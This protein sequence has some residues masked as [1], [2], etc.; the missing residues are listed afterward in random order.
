MYLFDF[1]FNPYALLSYLAVVANT[2]VLYLV[3]SR[4]LK[5]SAN[6]WFVMTVLALIPWGLGEAFLRLSAN[7]TAASFWQA[8]EII[9][10]VFVSPLFLSFTLAYI[11]KENLLSRLSVQALLFGPALLFLFLGWYTDL[12]YVT[13]DPA[14]YEKVYHGWMSPT[15]PFFW[16]VTLWL[17]SLFIISIW[18]LF[19]YRRGLKDDKKRKQTILVIFGVLV[20]IV[21]GLTTNA[22]LPLLGFMVFEAAVPLTT[23][24][25]VTIAYAIF[26]YKLFVINLAMVADDIV[27]TMNEILIVLDTGHFI[28]FGNNAVE[29][30]LGYKKEELLGQHVRKLVGSDWPAFRDK[31]LQ[32]LDAG[33][34]V[35]GVEVNLESS[36]GKKIPVSFSS[37]LLKDENG[38]VFG[39]VGVATD[40]RKIQELVTN[41][42]AERNKL[43]TVMQSI[44]DGVL[45]LDLEGNIILVNPPAL[46]MLGLGREDILGKKL[47]DVLT[48]FDGDQRML[49]RDLIPTNK[50]DKDTI[51]VQK[52]NLKI[53]TNFGRQLFV[54]LTSSS[55]KEGSEVGL[56]AIIT[57]N[58]ISKEKEFEEMKLDFVSMAAHE[59]RTPLTAIR[60]YL[61][62]LQEEV[63]D[64]LSKEQKSFLD[65]AFVSSSQLASLVEN[66]LSVSR[67]ERGAM[68]LD[69]IPADW[70]AILEESVNNFLPLASE[71]GVNIF[72]KC[73]EKLP[74]VLVDK[75]RIGEV[76][77][78]LVGNAIAYTKPGGD[79]QVTAEVGRGQVTT[80]VKDTGQGIPESALPRLFTKFFRVSGI[81]EQGSKGTGLGLYISK[82]IIDLHQGK[83]WVES[84]MGVGSTF[85]FTV[86]AVESGDKPVES[87]KEPLLV[88]ETKEG[89][90]TSSATESKN[91]SHPLSTLGNKKPK[92]FFKKLLTAQKKT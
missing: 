85:S 20:P 54:N 23:V 78:N 76:L 37:S 70:R 52:R 92:R 67:I 72:L 11:G 88:E 71:K 32:E 10:W 7:P 51:V 29:R 49:G 28:G 13:H 15:A 84:K 62:V 18:L 80:H 69:V 81:L 33:R 59:L 36:S 2:I 19:K 45:A 14:S 5:V 34:T 25:S 60:G 46:T 38:Q 12:I 16:L 55:I 48:M 4:G 17:M 42:T 79:I 66:L 57:I 90:N 56:G 21:G 31:V 22:I 74:K 58:D 3:V 1:A 65:K 86:P 91:V 47:D 27:E 64:S 83:I 43:T 87:G 53:V 39:E 50:P 30:I 73:P 89:K 35:S 63:A 77:S 44:V 75:F 68:R 40:I 41:V 9:G 82:A 61:S 6:R 26:K 24:M 8:V